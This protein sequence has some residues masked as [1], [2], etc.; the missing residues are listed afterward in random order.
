MFNIVYV[1]IL[2][3]CFFL[4]CIN[5]IVYVVLSL[6]EWINVID[7]IIYEILLNVEKYI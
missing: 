3:Y 2:V 1:I 6:K 7:K 5:N 4:L